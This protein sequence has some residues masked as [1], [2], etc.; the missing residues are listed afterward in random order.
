VKGKFELA[1]TGTL[2]I[3]EI[4]DMSSAAQAK[5][6]RA[7]EYGEYERLGSEAIEY[8]DVRLVSA[9]H[10]PI[11]RFIETDH[12]RRDLFYRI[13]GLTITV[14]PLRDRP[15][16]LRALV[17]TEISAAARAQNKT[18][19]GL[20]RQAA[21]KLFAYRWPGNL[22]ELQRVIHTAVA[23]TTGEVIYPQVILLE[24]EVPSVASTHAASAAARVS[25][26]ASAATPASEASDLSLRGA[27]SRH[28]VDVLARM[29]GCKRRAARALGVSRSTLDRKLAERART[30]VVGGA[31]EVSIPPRVVLESVPESSGM[32][33]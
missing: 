16:D 24:S 20:S 5:I 3:D 19:V 12:F 1:H 4:A 11:K 14:P 17:G 31:S 9:T 25:P 2:F 29:G 7:V 21:E 26:Q 13:S 33:S 10:L 8:A 22:R 28:I 18:I 15:T 30:G 32:L 23:M 27:E 6:L